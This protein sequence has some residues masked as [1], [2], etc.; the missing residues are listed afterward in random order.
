MSD[1]I[2]SKYRRVEAYIREREDV[3][4]TDLIQQFGLS[5]ATVRRLLT[6]FAAE[7]WMRRYHGGATIVSNDTQTPFNRRLVSNEDEKRGIGRLAAT[8]VKDGMTIMLLGGTTVGAMCPFLHHLKL[9]VI[10]NSLPVVN[11][12]SEFS[13]IQVIVL[14]GVLN[15]PEMEMRGTLTER[16]LA[17]LRADQMFIGATG[18]HPQHGLMTDDPNAIATYRQCMTNCETVFL[19]ADASK[20]TAPRGTGTVAAINEIDHIVTNMRFSARQRQE[21][22]GVDMH[23]TEL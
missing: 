4:V 10:T 16:S 8:F 2:A 1:S 11:A 12:L 19:L 15:P 9:T 22:A 3:T 14:G 13:Q 6:A 18:I 5:P 7:G 20:F 17:R 21:Y 23:I